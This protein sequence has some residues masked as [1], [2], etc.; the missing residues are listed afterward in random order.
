M[1]SHTVK[2]LFLDRDGI[3]N[4]DHGYVG[5]YEDFEYVDGIF[6]LIKRF[7]K[8]GYKIIIVTN[9]SGIARGLYSEDDFNALMSAVQQD[10]YQAGIGKVSVYFCPHHPEH[11]IGAYKKQC[12]CR[13]PNPGMLLQAAEEHS[14]SLPLSIMIGDSWRDIQAGQKVSLSHCYFVSRKAPP[15]GAELGNVTQVTS[16]NDIPVPSS[17]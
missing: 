9:Q 5:R 4:V 11:G 13:K 15:A 17:V 2:A 10:F 12:A 7:E 16:L 3:I 8:A 1:G 14:V 6:A